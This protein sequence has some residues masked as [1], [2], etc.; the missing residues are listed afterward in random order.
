MKPMLAL[1]T[2]FVTNCILES[3]GNDVP[4]ATITLQGSIQIKKKYIPYRVELFHW[5]HVYI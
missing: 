5:K 1:S 4:T 3:D 2:L